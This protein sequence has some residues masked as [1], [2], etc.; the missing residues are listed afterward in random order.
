MLGLAALLATPSALRAQYAIDFNSD[1]QGIHPNGWQSV[2][3]NRVTFAATG[4]GVLS[5]CSLTPESLGSPALCAFPYFGAEVGLEMTFT[6]YMESIAFDF[7]GD[8]PLLI[9]PSGIGV[10]RLTLFDG[11]SLVGMVDMIP[12]GNAVMDQ[13][14]TYSGTAFDRAIFQYLPELQSAGL[15]E[16]IDN[17]EFARARSVPEPAS[18]AL[19]L[20]GL[21]A[22]AASRRRRMA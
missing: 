3:S 8:D 5:V 4:S 2:Q 10:A 14:M 7:G 19:L 16:I 18:L 9:F 13:R 12:N 17:L 21:A 6:E 11:V 1:P 15:S 22:M 20:I